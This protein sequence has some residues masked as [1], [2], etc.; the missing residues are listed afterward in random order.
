[1]INFH[2]VQHKSETLFGKN[3]KEDINKTNLKFEDAVYSN[4]H[5]YQHL[6]LM[7]DQVYFILVVLMQLKI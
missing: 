2:I 7:I 4:K 3:S 5:N 1:M 6:P